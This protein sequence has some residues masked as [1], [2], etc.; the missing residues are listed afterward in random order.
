MAKTMNTMKQRS[1]NFNAV[2]Q[3]EHLAHIMNTNRPHG[4]RPFQAS[5]FEENGTQG[6]DCYG[7]PITFDVL[8]QHVDATVCLFAREFCGRRINKGG[9]DVTVEYVGYNTEQASNLHNHL[10]IRVSK[11]IYGAQ[12]VKALEFFAPNI[13]IDIT[14]NTWASTMYL[15][16]GECDWKNVCKRSD[17]TMSSSEV[18]YGT[19]SEILLKQFPDW[20]KN[21][22]VMLKDLIEWCNQNLIDKDGTT[23]GSECNA[24][25]FGLKYREHFLIVAGNFSD[26][27]D[28]VE[29]WLMPKTGKNFQVGAEGQSGGNKR[30]CE[31]SA[32]SS[33]KQ[34]KKEEIMCDQFIELT[35]SIIEEVTNGAKHR[36]R[37][38]VKQLKKLE[39]D[40]LFKH[41]MYN[42][43]N[44]SK[45]DNLIEK[46]SQFFI[47]QTNDLLPKRGGRYLYEDFNVFPGYTEWYE[48][49]HDMTCFNVQISGFTGSGKTARMTAKLAEMGIDPN[50]R[51]QLWRTAG[52]DESFNGYGHVPGQEAIIFE[53]LDAFKL[54]R[55]FK[56]ML[57]LT[58][59]VSF[60]VRKSHSSV[61][62]PVTASFCIWI[63]TVPI[64]LMYIRYQL[65]IEKHNKFEAGLDPGQL[66]R[67]WQRME[68]VYLHGIEKPPHVPD[69]YLHLGDDG[70]WRSMIWCEKSFV[71]RQ[72][73]WYLHEDTLAKIIEGGAV[74]LLTTDKG[75]GGW[76]IC[77]ETG[78]VSP[79][80]THGLA[81]QA[82]S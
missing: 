10:V 8:K 27:F 79:G 28:R 26:Y 47:E 61:D 16:K 49:N 13:H 77:P 44:K 1:Q 76:D 19:V 38:L 68:V 65:E 62:H 69:E 17:G 40:M 29:H 50:D 43:L 70:N 11:R 73:T 30:S 37:Y 25:L 75:Q 42:V 41:R 24:G 33:N 35:T 34:S 6:T 71:Q 55:I 48:N 31:H 3:A 32:V 18:E 81:E 58:E 72:G 51:T 9:D 78:E 39:T 2:L 59:M 66:N 5:D 82:A 54:K 63:N 12:M 15:C 23:F 67:R 60:G 64:L 14:D 7:N 4:L 21:S 45:V 52:Q 56:Y 20:L 80:L 22:T 74:D 57:M 46:C 36:L 53:E